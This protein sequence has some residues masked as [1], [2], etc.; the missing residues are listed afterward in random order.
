M[1]LLGHVPRGVFA[2]I[3]EDSLVCVVTRRCMRCIISLHPEVAERILLA[4]Y[5]YMEEL[6]DRLEHATF[7]SVRVRLARFLLN[8]MDH[9]T[10]AV[11]G[12]IHA[13]IGDTI[14]ALRQTVT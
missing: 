9:G 8:N 6:K 13:D 5:A 11:S 12:F 10:R 7:S 14:G 3:I 4:T 1:A 2:E